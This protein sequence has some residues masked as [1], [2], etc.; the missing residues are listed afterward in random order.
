MIKKILRKISIEIYKTEGVH[1]QFKKYAHMR[2]HEGWPVHQS[3]LV[4]IANKLAETMLSE[5]FTRLDKDEKDVQQQALYNTKEIIDFLLDP[6]KGANTYANVKNWQRKL[7]A[8]KKRKRPQ[9]G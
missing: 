2:Q 5:E 1:M 6:L 4:S 8:T 7:E 3:M 9:G